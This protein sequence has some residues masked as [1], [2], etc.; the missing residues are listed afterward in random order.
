MG[1]RREEEGVVARTRIGARARTRRRRVAEVDSN[2]QPVGAAQRAPVGTRDEA[3]AA[4]AQRSLRVAIAVRACRELGNIGART[5]L[6]QECA[7][8]L[9]NERVI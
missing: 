1:A 2:E 7:V 9:F 4:N 8:C 5:L 6:V 3:L